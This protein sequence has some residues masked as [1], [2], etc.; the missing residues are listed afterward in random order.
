MQGF[1]LLFPLLGNLKEERWKSSKI[2]EPRI[3]LSCKVSVIGFS[4]FL[5]TYPFKRYSDH[6]THQLNASL[7]VSYLITYGDYCLD[8][9]LVLHRSKSVM[10]M[11]YLLFCD[12][13]HW[14]P[15][16][17][18][19][20]GNMN[21][22]G[23]TFWFAMERQ[24]LVASC[25]EESAFL[26]DHNAVNEHFVRLRRRGTEEPLCINLDEWY[27]FARHCFLDEARHG[28]IH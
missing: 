2:E 22:F 28:R 21:F 3:Y 5:W 17:A 4:T 6:S 9:P 11:K 12:F 19:W 7:L 20:N 1:L 27:N 10:V 24:V 18:P 14:H 23:I 15:F 26:G 13:L 16:H 25:K 8:R